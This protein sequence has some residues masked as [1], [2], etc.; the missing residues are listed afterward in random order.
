VR[1]RWRS[2]VLIITA[3]VVG[4][5]V[6]FIQVAVGLGGIGNA[7]VD[8]S[9]ALMRRTTGFRLAEEIDYRGYTVGEALR[10]IESDLWHNMRFEIVILAALL[11]VSGWLAWRLRRGN[12]A[13]TSAGLWPQWRLL[14]VFFLAGVAFWVLML[15]STVSQAGSAYRPALPF[16]GLAAGYCVINVYRYLRLNSEKLAVRLL[17]LLAVVIIVAPTLQDRLSGRPFRFTGSDQRLDMYDGIYPAEIKMLGGFLRGSTEYGDII[18]TNLRVAET[19]HPRYPFP[20]YEYES[21]RRV[22]YTKDI[23]QAVTAIIEFTD[24]RGGMA[25]D[26]PASRVAFYLLVDDGS[27]GGDYGRFA[28]SVGGPATTFYAADYWTG[29]YGTVPVPYGDTIP[30][31]PRSFYL[32]RVD[33]IKFEHYLATLSGGTSG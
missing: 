33:D 20:G 25:A 3:P 32:F 27:I 23:G 10:K 9:S 21:G 29:L 28:Q 1:Q 11:A 13:D 26:N 5:A 2:A 17:V 18:I 14:L 4:Q 15:Q 12:R 16:F 6:H 22:E 8:F 19:G 24:I 31:A 30:F 7:F